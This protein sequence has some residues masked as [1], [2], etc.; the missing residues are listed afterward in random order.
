MQIMI[1]IILK[2]CDME[3]QHYFTL[4]SPQF[5]HDNDTLQH[6]YHDNYLTRGID[7]I[8]SNASC[9]CDRFLSLSTLLS[10]VLY[11]LILDDDCEFIFVTAA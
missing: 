3:T 6:S 8:I 11:S 1:V 7:L 4:F 5:T 10:K 2:L 9:A